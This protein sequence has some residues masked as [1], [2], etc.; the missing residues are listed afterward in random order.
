MSI[1]FSKFTFKVNFVTVYQLFRK[2]MCR[3]KPRERNRK[4]ALLFEITDY[5]GTDHDLKGC[6]N[7]HKGFL[8]ACFDF[9]VKAFKNSQVTKKT[10]ITELHKAI[11]ELIQD[12]LLVIH[13][14]GHGTQ[15][16][17]LNGDEEDQFDEGLYVID[18]V[19]VDDDI[20]EALM[21]IPVGAT[22]VIF[23]DSC[24]SGTATK[25]AYTGYKKGKFIPGTGTFLEKKNSS[26]FKSEKI[27]WIVFS[28]CSENQT[29][30]DA[31]IDGKYWGAFSYYALKTLSRNLTYKEWYQ[32]IREY[33]PSYY[34]DQIPTLEGP[35]E[36]LNQKV[37]Y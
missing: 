37:F 23:L 3:I 13:Y 34:F 7:D 32:K 12:D 11:S 33:L 18:G 10:F 17:D 4:K 31:F 9:E 2:Y 30:E 5:K 8:K 22:V 25:H 26:V 27:N 1:D 28:G 16:K 6:I 21:G 35:E 14:S 36:L 29:S 19:V 24:F 20:H 15:V